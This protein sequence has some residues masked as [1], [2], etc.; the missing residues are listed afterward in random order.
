M[1]GEFLRTNYRRTGNRLDITALGRNIIVASAAG[2]AGTI[3]PRGGLIWCSMSGSFNATG[4]FAQSTYGTLSLFY[5]SSYFG[6]GYLFHPIIAYMLSFSTVALTDVAGGDS[7]PD[8]RPV[9]FTT[10]D[11]VW[12]ICAMKVSAAGSA[13]TASSVDARLLVAG[14]IVSG[15]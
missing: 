10:S 6:S 5:G 14:F 11:S 9:N 7:V 4:Q 8:F 1:A 3:N 13:T 12:Y 2:G 15:P